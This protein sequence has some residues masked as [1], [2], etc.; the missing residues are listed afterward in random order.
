[1]RRWLAERPR[2]ASPSSM[3]DDIEEMHLFKAIFSLARDEA[4]RSPTR[5]PGCDIVSCGLYNRFG[6]EPVRKQTGGPAPW[7][8]LHARVRPLFQ[9]RS[10]RSAFTGTTRYPFVPSRAAEQP[11][12]HISAKAGDGN[13]SDASSGHRSGDISR[14]GLVLA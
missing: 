3:V 2:P 9:T 6:A 5:R 14:S 4:R 1:V 13:V 7:A 12:G 8:F 10:T 11:R